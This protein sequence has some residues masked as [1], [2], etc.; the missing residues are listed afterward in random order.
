M[1]TQ[2]AN[3]VRDYLIA[4]GYPCTISAVSS[5]LIAISATTTLWIQGVD[6]GDRKPSLLAGNSPH[7]SLK[8]GATH[9]F[10]IQ[11][12]DRG[13]RSGGVLTSDTASV[14]VPYPS[15]DGSEI[16]LKFADTSMSLQAG[17][18]TTRY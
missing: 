8:K 18:G 9:E 2:I 4:L 5:S 16:T 6:F 17:L 7:Q 12:Y 13:M 14:Y 10:G 1:F 15:Q 11:Y 3:T